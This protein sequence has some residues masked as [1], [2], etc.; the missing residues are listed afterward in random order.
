MQVVPLQHTDGMGLQDEEH[1]LHSV[2]SV[3]REVKYRDIRTTFS[4]IMTKTEMN[5]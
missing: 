2:L 3:E 4:M 1:V 5:G